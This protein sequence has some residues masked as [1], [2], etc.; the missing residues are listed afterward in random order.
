MSYGGTAQMGADPTEEGRIPTIHSYSQ[1]E[2]SSPRP[3][4]ADE[5][6]AYCQQVTMANVLGNPAPPMPEWMGDSM[7]GVERRI[8]GFHQDRRPLGGGLGVWAHAACPARPSLDQPNLDHNSRRPCGVRRQMSRLQEVRPLRL[9]P[10][11][12]PDALNTRS[13]RSAR[14]PSC[15]LGIPSPHP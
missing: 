10:K 4:R 2:A 3:K 1:G 7:N 15:S 5:L 9:L 14:S 6:W 13:D 8:V 11:G 12:P